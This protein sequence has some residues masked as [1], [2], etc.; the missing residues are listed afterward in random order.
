MKQPEQPEQMKQPE[1]AEQMKQAEQAEQMKQPEQAEQMKQP[2]QAEQAEQME[3]PEQAEQMEQ[4]VQPVQPEQ[5]EEM[6]YLNELDTMKDTGSPTSTGE[7]PLDEN[8]VEFSKMIYVSYN[9]VIKN[10]KAR[11][12]IG[13]QVKE[14]MLDICKLNNRNRLKVY[15]IRIG[16]RTVSIEIG[17][18]ESDN[19]DELTS[20]DIKNNIVQSIVCW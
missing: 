5:S 3:L 18:D 14:N 7:D 20:K 16:P 19:A 10:D 15:R 1:Q 12:S 17:I 13:R 2:E 4:P 8:V 6:K 11:D 9:G